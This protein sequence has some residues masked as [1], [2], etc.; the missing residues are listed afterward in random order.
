MTRNTHRYTTHAT[1]R[2]EKVPAGDVGV[3]TLM[4]IIAAMVAACAL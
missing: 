4:V 1:G 3:V 2:C